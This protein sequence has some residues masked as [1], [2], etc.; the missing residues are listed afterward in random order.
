M[1][2]D[3]EAADAKR[4]EWDAL[5]PKLR[6]EQEREFDRMKQS[7]EEHLRWLRS[8]RLAHAILGGLLVMLPMNLSVGFASIP[9]LPVDAIL[10]AAGGL[11]LNRLRGGAWHGFG[12]FVGTAVLSMILRLPFLNVAEYLKGY[13]FFTCFAMLS[14]S[15]GGYL[16]GMKLEYEHRDHFVTG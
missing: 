8:N 5:S 15:G 3:R 16:M 9:S 13:W 14:V 10:G 2:Q 12:L 6:Q 4:R 7:T 11:Y 1:L